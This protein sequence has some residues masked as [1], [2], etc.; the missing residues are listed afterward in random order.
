MIKDSLFWMARRRS[1]QTAVALLDRLEDR[2]SDLLRVVTYHRVNHADSPP[3]LYSG[4][5][6][7]SPDAFRRQM[8]LLAE[9]FRVIDLNELLRL[10][11]DGQRL[12]PR[13]LLI[14]FDDAYSD[15]A[16]FAWPA[17]QE[18]KLP[19]TLF[20]ATG[21]PDRLQGGFW[22][23][24][25][26]QAFRETLRREPLETP[27]GALPLEDDPGERSTS[28]RRMM[29]LVKSLPHDE[30]MDLVDAACQ[31]LGVVPCRNHVLSW[32]ELRRLASEGV[33]LAPH[34]RT[35]PLMNRVAP[36]RAL[37]EALGSWEDLCGQVSETPR[38]IAYPAGGVNQEVV[39]LLREAEF[40]FAFTTQ[41][42]MND[43][44]KADPL[45]LR[46][47][48]VGFRT[49][50]SMLHAQLLPQARHFYL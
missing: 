37:D 26:H 38:V 3:D 24:R 12:P 25:I 13:S 39:R 46:R 21:F 6:S 34:T 8:E 41:R 42:G 30:A 35:H 11:R 49:S 36:Q 1:F 40:E 47:I 50:P 16:E 15:F 18:L 43:M 44:T 10:R 31:E 17:M 48:N 22:W 7:A 19:V 27:E 5:I 23:D 28:A 45:L 14:T 2:R 33:R 4:L 20:V 32:D 29:N 9:R